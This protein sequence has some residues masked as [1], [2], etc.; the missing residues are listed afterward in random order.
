MINKNLIYNELYHSVTA[1]WEQTE[2][3]VA[4]KMAK[5]ATLA[6]YSALT[7]PRPE[8]MPLPACKKGCNCCCVVNVA[9][10]EPEAEAIAVH[11]IT[12][13]LDS[14]FLPKLA[15]MANRVRFTSEA[16][17]ILMRIPCPFLDEAGG[18]GIHPVRPLVCRGITSLH[19]EDCRA[20]IESVIMG[21]EPSCI[22]H[23]IAQKEVFDTAFIALAD[24]LK[25]Q[26]GN[27]RSGELCSMVYDILRKPGS[28][29]P[30]LCLHR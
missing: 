9:T 4:E 6:E 24:V 3:S 28:K 7:T 26:G 17:R 14:I 20:S 22:S 8:D 21:D 13:G 29:A 10:L 2:L 16:E 19:A 1:A 15:S 25:A 23:D 12:H 30:E 18:C 27:C 5:I 11:I